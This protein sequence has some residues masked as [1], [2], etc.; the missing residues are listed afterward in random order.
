MGMCWEL[1]WLLLLRRFWS[2]DLRF[3]LFR[4]VKTAGAYVM[5]QF[6]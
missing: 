3:D 5:G 4:R 6:V 2:D 1:R